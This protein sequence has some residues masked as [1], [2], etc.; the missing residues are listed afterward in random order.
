MK[1]VANSTTAFLWSWFTTEGFRTEATPQNCHQ[2]SNFQLA[3]FSSEPHLPDMSLAVDHG[4]WDF[5]QNAFHTSINGLR[6]L[7]TT[8]YHP[9]LQDFMQERFFD[10]C[11][12]R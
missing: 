3:A 11:L 1:S 7:N 9:C 5:H 12:N 6:L 4:G 8:A 10:L 2:E